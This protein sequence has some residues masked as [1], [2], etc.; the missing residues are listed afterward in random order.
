MRPANPESAPYQ[1]Q[2]G[3]SPIAPNS[4]RDT[5]HRTQSFSVAYEFPVVFTASLFQPENPVLVETLCRLEPNRE[6]RC[7]VF[8]DNGLLATRP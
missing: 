7:L 8:I 5:L 6:H 3:P 1:G 2:A 4:P